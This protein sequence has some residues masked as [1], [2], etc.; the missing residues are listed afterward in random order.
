[1]YH[2]KLLQFSRSAHGL[3][4]LVFLSLIIPCLL[5]AVEN[6]ATSSRRSEG[7]I[8]THISGGP[9]SDTKR[10]D[11]TQP[12][13]SLCVSSPLPAQVCAVYE[14]FWPFSHC[15]VFVHLLSSPSWSLCFSLRIPCFFL[16][17][18][19][20]TRVCMFCIT[21]EFVY[22][23]THLILCILVYL[24]HKYHTH[25]HTHTHTFSFGVCVVWEFVW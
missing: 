10:S 18:L 5:F 16:H 23:L 20:H 3:P 25:T 2:V 1:M 11:S 22:Y 7:E 24:F 17:L 12:S 13:S 15:L 8:S 21:L 6:V 14:L 4:L 19:Y 9:S